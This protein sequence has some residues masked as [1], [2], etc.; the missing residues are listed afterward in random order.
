MNLL[1]AFAR[2][3]YDFIVGD[4]WKI[5][6]AVFLALAILAVTL[7][8]GL[9]GD[10]VLTVLGGLL[11]LAAFSISLVIDVRSHRS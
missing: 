3:W 9:F 6:V 1:K 2:F 5:P 8:L 11:V 7:S 4:D 10:A